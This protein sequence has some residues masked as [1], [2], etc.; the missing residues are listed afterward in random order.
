M[1]GLRGNKTIR[2]YHWNLLNMNDVL[3]FVGLLEAH[4]W[5]GD[6]PAVRLDSVLPEYE[7]SSIS[8]EPAQEWRSGRARDCLQSCGWWACVF[9]ISYAGRVLKQKMVACRQY[10]LYANLLPVLMCALIELYTNRKDG[11]RALI[12]LKWIIPI[13]ILRSWSNIMTC[14]SLLLT[15][16]TWTNSTCQLSPPLIHFIFCQLEVTD[17]VHCTPSVTSR[18]R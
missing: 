1:C 17:G 5:D 11:E 2:H 8:F 6:R 15:K 9:L 13:S 10:D 18:I 4:T 12:M 3:K 14:F 16:V 7:N